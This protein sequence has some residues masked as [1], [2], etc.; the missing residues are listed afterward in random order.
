MFESQVNH[1]TDAV[2]LCD[3]RWVSRY[4]PLASLG[5]SRRCW[6]WEIPAWLVLSLPPRT[7][8]KITHD[9]P[10]VIMHY[11]MH[12][13]LSHYIPYTY[14]YLRVSTTCLP[15]LLYVLLTIMN[16]HPPGFTP[17]RSSR[18]VLW[19]TCA[20]SSFRRQPRRRPMPTMTG[21]RRRAP[22]SKGQ[23]RWSL[24]GFHWF[25]QEKWWL[26][27]VEWNLDVVSWDVN[28]VIYMRFWW[29]FNGT[30]MVIL[31][32][33]LWDVCVQEDMTWSIHWIVDTGQAKIQLRPSVPCGN[34]I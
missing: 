29:W 26:I 23:W 31:W 5:E 17:G 8:H 30:W 7:H 2:F 21:R 15:V 6:Q 1:R 34:L 27:W 22:E 11:W 4:C 24:R 20:W 14:K 19:A 3:F 12:Y 16:N 32:W 18:A 25:H 28:M 9:P 10:M 33:Y 13:W